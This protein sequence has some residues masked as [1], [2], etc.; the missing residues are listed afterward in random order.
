MTAPKKT[1]E[2]Q[3]GNPSAPDNAHFTRRLLD[4]ACKFVARIVGDDMNALI[5]LAMA[6]VFAAGASLALDLVGALQ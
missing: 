3:K 4:S 5:N 6:T 2:P 1:P